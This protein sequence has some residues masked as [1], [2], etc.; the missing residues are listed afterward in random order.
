M[1]I[2][3][4]ILAIVGIAALLFVVACA[5]A[6]CKISSEISREEEMMQLKEEYEKRKREL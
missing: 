4:G 1:K 6:A 5:F 3:L 2:L